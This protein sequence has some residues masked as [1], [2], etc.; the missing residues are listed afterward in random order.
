MRGNSHVQFLMGKAAETPLTYITDIN[1]ENKF[2]AL[3][4]PVSHS[5]RHRHLHF[6][7]IQTNR[8]IYRPKS[9]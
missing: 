3:R 2:K 6:A 4:K 7:V 9:L 5:D 1:Y 8:S